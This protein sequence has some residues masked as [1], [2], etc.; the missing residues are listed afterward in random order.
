MRNLPWINCF[1]SKFLLIGLFFRFFQYADGSAQENENEQPNVLLILIDDLNDWTG[2]LNGHPN[3]LTPNIDRLAENGI[4]FTNAHCVVPKCN[5]S[6][7][8]LLSGVAPHR[9]GVY[10]NWDPWSGSEV[11]RD[12]DHLPMLFKKNGYHTMMGGKVFHGRPRNIGLDQAVDEE[13]GHT[14]GINS[15]IISR[16]YTYPFAG[17]A[18]RWNYAV[19]WGPLDDPDASQLSDQKTEA[20]AIERLNQRYDQPFFLAVGFYRPHTPLTA[21]REF[22]ERFKQEEVYL[23][24]INEDDLDDVPRMGREIALTG[25]GEI[26][27]SLYKQAKDR[28]VLRDIVKGYLA[29]GTYVDAKI[30]NVLKALEESPYKDNTI[31]ILA[32]DHGWSVGEQTHIRKSVLWEATTRVPL[33]IYVPGM[34]SKGKRSNAGVTLLDIYPTLVDLCGF[35]PPDH[36]L[37]GLS[38]LPLLE[39][40]ENTRWERPAMTTYGRNNHALR[41]ERWRYIRYADGTE[42]LYDHFNDPGEWHN[43]AGLQENQK[44]KKSLAKWFPE[45]NVPALNTDHEFPV[46]LTPGDNSRAFKMLTTKFVNHPISIKAT[47]GPEIGDGIIVCQ[48]SQFAGYS[49]Y[50]LNGRLCFSIMD[51]PSPLWWDNLYPTRTIVTSVNRLPEKKQEIEARLAKNGEVVLY[52]NGEKIGSGMA[53]TLSIHPAGVMT[54][55]EAPERFVPAGNYDPPFKFRGDIEEVIVDNK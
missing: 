2:V 55:G 53:K 18:G 11:L 42:E 1:F 37:D 17:L 26:Q 35:P 19:H 14:G 29:A 25:Y 31:V 40:P 7:T 27:N 16:D 24:V 4:L 8:S 41:S 36:D 6:R 28:G 33:I 30:G 23:P 15:R 44:T 46:R 38:L 5:P 48:G 39:D 12:A 45:I 9:S 50:V 34:E 22:F 32:S 52:A 43:V 21:P 10:Q 54:L 3:A 13:L 49:L 47:I 20:W 51:V